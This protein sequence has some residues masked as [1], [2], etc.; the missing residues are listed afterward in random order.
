MIVS[1][2]GGT[3]VGSSINIRKVINIIGSKT[4]KW[5]DSLDLIIDVLD[6]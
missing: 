2:F 4:D 5:F 1:K 3:S 6:C